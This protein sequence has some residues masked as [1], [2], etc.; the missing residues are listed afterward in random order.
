MLSSYILA[1]FFWRIV[2]PNGLH[3]RSTQ[4]G[5]AGD[6]D[7]LDPAGR[8]EVTPLCRN[9]LEPRELLENAASPTRRVHAVLGGIAI[10][11][12]CS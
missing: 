6:L 7:R 9:R 5:S 8:D 1:I 10:V 3:L 4:W 2:L 11:F 12:Y